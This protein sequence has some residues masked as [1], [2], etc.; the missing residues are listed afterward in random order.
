MPF[1]R[2]DR[3][4]SNINKPIVLNEIGT[5]QNHQLQLKGIKTVLKSDNLEPI[6]QGGE[7]D[8]IESNITNDQI[9]EFKKRK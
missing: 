5:Y 6:K 8:Q 7:S 3:V 9:K 1:L 2:I 4:I